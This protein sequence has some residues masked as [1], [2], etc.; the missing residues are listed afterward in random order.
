[1]LRNAHLPEFLRDRRPHAGR[2]QLARR[3]QRRSDVKPL[4]AGKDD[5]NP[6]G[7]PELKHPYPSDSILPVSQNKA[8]AYY[9]EAIVDEE[10]ITGEAVSLDVR[11]T[12]FAIRGV[13]VLIDMVVSGLLLFAL[14]IIVGTFATAGAIDS[15]LTQALSIAA[16][17][18]ALVIYP[19]TIET[20]TRGRSVGKI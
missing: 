19:I 4:K 8:P 11:A 6:F 7:G 18:I 9:S 15:A 10:L 2:V 17:V 12:S 20:L 1:M 13:G 16:V 14:L 3:L 5:P